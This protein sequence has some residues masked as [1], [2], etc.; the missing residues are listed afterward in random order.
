MIDTS[1]LGDR[2]RFAFSNFRAN[3]ER[4]CGEPLELAV[5]AGHHINPGEPPDLSICFGDHSLAETAFQIRGR[6]FDDVGCDETG[7][8]GHRAIL[9]R[10]SCHLLRS[11]TAISEE[12]VRNLVRAATFA[13]PVLNRG[14]PMV[15]RSPS[16]VRRLGVSSTPDPL[17][18]ATD[19]TPDACMLILAAP[20]VILPLRYT[21]SFTWLAKC[22]SYL[23]YSHALYAMR[24]TPSSGRRHARRERV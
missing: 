16:M 5:V 4:C 9:R 15:E 7:G 10:A 18:A 13:A 23:S 11:K 19:H 3:H 24:H 1:S 6:L 14:V 22:E 2:A 12:S 8:G 20:P 21:S 17:G